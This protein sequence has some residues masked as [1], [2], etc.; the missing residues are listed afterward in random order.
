[1]SDLEFFEG[2]D[3]WERFKTLKNAMHIK[4]VDEFF[5]DL[6][7]KVNCKGENFTK[8][9]YGSELK[10]G[11]FLTREDVK[12]WTERFGVEITEKKRSTIDDHFEKMVEERC[13]KK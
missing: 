11:T 9:T 4:A 2:P 8:I 7:Q 5:E 1:M 6:R 3:G 10:D 13:T 12:S